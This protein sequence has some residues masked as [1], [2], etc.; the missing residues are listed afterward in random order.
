MQFSP[1]EVERAC[2]ELHELM[3]L[4][5]GMNPEAYAAAL[6]IVR[7]L[8]AS[9][10]LHPGSLLFEIEALLGRWFTSEPWA[11][12]D[13]PVRMRETLLTYLRRVEETWADDSADKPRPR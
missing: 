4:G 8:K 12:G 13:E 10:P 3:D 7:R 11:S 5:P 2:D 6:N 9:A 1:E